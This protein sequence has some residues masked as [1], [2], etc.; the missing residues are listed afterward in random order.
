L[1]QQEDEKEVSLYYFDESGFSTASSIPYAWQCIGETREL[2]KQRSKRLNVLG[3]LSRKGRSFFHTIEQ[4]AKSEDVIHIF[5]AFSEQYYKEYQQTRVPC[6][7]VLDNASIHRSRAFTEKISRW[8][9]KAV[10]LHFLPAYSPELNLIEI[11][12]RRIKYHWLPLDAYESYAHLKREVLSIL[13]NIG[14]KYVIT[15]T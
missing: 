14:E 7:I 9:S 6:I 13:E 11:L 10:F 15:F 8:E 12:W 5:D 2:P 3:F 4:S 1:K